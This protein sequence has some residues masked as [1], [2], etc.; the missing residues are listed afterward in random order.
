MPRTP[1]NRANLRNGRVRV[2]QAGREA[3]R[4]DRHRA[5]RPVRYVRQTDCARLCADFG[6]IFAG[7]APDRRTRP[8]LPWHAPQSLQTV[9]GP[10]RSSLWPCA[11]RMIPAALG[12]DIEQRCVRSQV[13]APG[14]RLSLRQA[15][16]GPAAI[17]RGERAPRRQQP[18][19]PR[20]PST[21]I[22][23]L[24]RSTAG[25]SVTPNVRAPRSRMRIIR[26]HGGRQFRTRS[27]SP[28]AGGH[29]VLMQPWAGVSRRWIPRDGCA[30]RDGGK[31]R[32][33]PRKRHL[34]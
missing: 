23:S 30:A 3:R 21:R 33:R 4:A 34:T 10:V 9:P 8:R 14:R 7:S 28:D 1:M 2:S 32:A 29:N 5:S 16:P 11:R 26:E 22:R 17:V 18:G 13:E 31:P 20:K 19:G 27:R 24:E 6:K 12:R 15:A 25:S